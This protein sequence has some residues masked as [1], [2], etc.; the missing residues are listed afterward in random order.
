MYLVSTSHMPSHH[1]I[2][3]H[4]THPHYIKET[5]RSF[6]ESYSSLPLPLPPLP[7][8]PPP[9]LRRPNLLPRLPL[10]QT[11]MINIPLHQRLIAQRTRER[12]RRR[13][14]LSSRRRRR[15]RSRSRSFLAAGR[16]RGSLAY[17]AGLNFVGG[18]L[19]GCGFGCGFGLRCGFGLGRGR[20]LRPL[21][22]GRFLGCLGRSARSTSGWWW[23][24][25]CRAG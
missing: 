4:S 23:A 2:P 14:E 22:C 15:R 25:L 7:P 9:H 10:I 6:R 13:R 8:L 24:V 19:L 1:I 18:G 20:F 5:I 3:S 17:A 16:G 12:A 21:G 11:P